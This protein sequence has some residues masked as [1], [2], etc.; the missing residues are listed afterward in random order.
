MNLKDSELKKYEVIKE[1]VE[2]NGS[3]YEA[4]KEL[5]VTLRH[6]N[7]LMLIYK[8]KG[9]EGFSHGNKNRKSPIAKKE[10]YTQNIINLYKTKY[11]NLNYNKFRK[12]LE[13]QENIKVSYYY[14]Y[15]TLKQENEKINKASIA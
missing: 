9:K 6:I 1:V 14:I 15:T 3:K 10:E 8:Q 7:R 5:G 4:A 13:K 12:I 2:N 11:S